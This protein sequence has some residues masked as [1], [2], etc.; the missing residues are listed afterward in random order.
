MTKKEIIQKIRQLMAE[1]RRIWVLNSCFREP[2]FINEQEAYMLRMELER[3]FGMN[4]ETINQE[5]FA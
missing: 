1:N 2:A 3:R 4:R 5:I